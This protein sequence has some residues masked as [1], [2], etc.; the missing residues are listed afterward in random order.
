MPVD[1]TGI[2]FDKNANLFLTQNLSNIIT[3]LHFTA[4]G[5]DEKG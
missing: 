4:E 1:F 5:S 2:G 3:K